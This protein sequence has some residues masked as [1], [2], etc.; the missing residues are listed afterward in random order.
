MEVN[1]GSTAVNFLLSIQSAGYLAYRFLQWDSVVKPGFQSQ[2][3]VYRILL[4]FALFLILS[5]LRLPWLEADAGSDAFRSFAYFQNDEGEYT[6]GGRI[7]YLT[8][9]FVDHDLKEPAMFLVSPM[10]HFIAAL[11]YQCLGLSLASV[12]LPVM[13]LAIGAWLA[14]FYSLSRK[15][16]AR[17]AFV[18]TLL[19]SLSPLILTYERTASTDVAAG[20]FMTFSMA[21][22]ESRFR[23]SF[24]IASV[25]M[26]IAIS[27]KLTMLAFV[28]L[29]AF[30]I[31]KRHRLRIAA[32]YAIF[33]VLGLVCM[34][35]LSL[36]LDQGISFS[37]PKADLNQAFKMILF[38]PSDWFK[39]L[40]IY[41]RWPLNTQLGA[42]IPLGIILPC[43]A[44][45]LTLPRLDRQTRI[46]T[47]YMFGMLFYVGLLAIQKIGVPRYHVPAHYFLPFAICASRISLKKISQA[48]PVSTRSLVLALFLI[49][50][51]FYIFW[52]P[53][54]VLKKVEDLRQG[55]YFM[56]NEN[57]WF[58][59][60]PWLGVGFIISYPLLRNRLSTFQPI[61]I[62]LFSTIVCILFF[63]NWNINVLDLYGSEV[64][65]AFF[66]QYHFAKDT[67]FLQL[68]I[69]VL[70]IAI[71]TVRNIH[72]PKLWFTVVS[73]IFISNLFFNS[74][75]ADGAQQ[76]ARRDFLLK[77][78]AGILESSIEQGSIVFG[79]RAT[80]W[81]RGTKL[82]LGF[83]GYQYHGLD[84]KLWLDH[85]FV[86]G[87][88]G[89]VYWLVDDDWSP[90]WDDLMQFND[91]TYKT[92]K[93]QVFN[94]YSYTSHE[95]VPVTLYRLERTAV[96][97][98]TSKE[99]K[100]K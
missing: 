98:N 40:S 12:R 87:L 63:S 41:P 83:G 82:R 97:K 78:Q 36:H 3:K 92:K 34:R 7:H 99:L 49:S 39:A 55:E 19:V 16:D 90:Q 33:L 50:I 4:G 6:T 2:Q 94:L 56:P 62:Y 72:Q 8:G 89:P 60:W 17:N 10:M 85:L 32:L 93:I 52:F 15:T 67:L 75:W 29:A 74:A 91:G 38:N 88:N 69:T 54:G 61:R 64:E 59:N 28:P 58:A 100:L 31:F 9:A 86:S 77:T 25:L 66:S 14:V 11:G 20:A 57:V 22:L 18:T 35:L 26:V 95:L 79:P 48:K 47:L 42:F 30:L 53:Q 70:M 43:L 96:L 68:T 44:A 21:C 37:G 76:L 46:W 24:V 65:H 13:L 80:T 45:C 71:L 81:L 84:F 1:R 27:T 51:I 73:F 23:G 5:S